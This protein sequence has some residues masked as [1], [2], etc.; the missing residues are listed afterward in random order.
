MVLERTPLQEHLI[1]SDIVKCELAVSKK[2]EEAIDSL[3]LKRLK[4][5]R[6]HEEIKMGWEKKKIK[7][8]SRCRD[9]AARY[10]NGSQKSRQS[11]RAKEKPLTEKK[12]NKQSQ[13][14]TVRKD[15]SRMQLGLNNNIPDRPARKPPDKA[16]KDSDKTWKAVTMEVEIGERIWAQ[17]SKSSKDTST[18]LHST[19]YLITSPDYSGKQPGAVAID[20]TT[21]E[22]GGSSV[23]LAASNS[24]FCKLRKDTEKVHWEPPDRQNMR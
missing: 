3:R 6:I 10:S 17:K 5:T 14:K 20:K 1:E 4:P 9:S 12:K 22:R 16:E 24:Q 13:R 7:M 11:G 8:G 21:G 19:A 18:S 23:L 2:K 15:R